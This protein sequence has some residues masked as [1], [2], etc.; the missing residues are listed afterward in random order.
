MDAGTDFFIRCCCFIY[1]LLFI[2]FRL[3]FRL[4]RFRLPCLIIFC[5][6]FFCLVSLLRL[7]CQFFFRL[8]RN[9]FFLCYIII[10]NGNSRF[11]PVIFGVF[12]LSI[13]SLIFCCI[14]HRLFF[15]V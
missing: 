5:F 1:S 6:R 2:R 4:F 14:F 3:L 12:I 15:P 9:R 11:F 13:N 8:L 7:F 10:L